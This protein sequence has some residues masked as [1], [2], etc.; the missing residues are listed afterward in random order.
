M[1]KVHCEAARF[2]IWKYFKKH[3]FYSHYWGNHICFSKNQQFFKNILTHCDVWLPFMWL[4]MTPRYAVHFLSLPHFMNSLAMRKVWNLGR[5][6]YSGVY[7]AI[8]DLKLPAFFKTI[9]T[10]QCNQWY[11]FFFV[12]VYYS[13]IGTFSC[14]RGPIVYFIEG[15]SPVNI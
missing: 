13:L 1:F 2:K 10:Q 5:S 4:E 14:A 15:R 6:F 9:S 7:I 8:I 3:W 12:K 11:T